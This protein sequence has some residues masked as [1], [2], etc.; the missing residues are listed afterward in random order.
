MSR[1]ALA[2]RLLNVCMQ[3]KHEIV[4]QGYFD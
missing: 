1:D 4:S 3:S 2:C